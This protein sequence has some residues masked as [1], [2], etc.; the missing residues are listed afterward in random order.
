MGREILGTFSPLVVFSLVLA[1]AIYAAFSQLGSAADELAE[2][3]YQNQ[4]MLIARQAAERLADLLGAVQR[5]LDMAPVPGDL[6]DFELPNAPVDVTVR[7]LE[8]GDTAS[9][10]GLTLERQ[11]EDVR[12]L[13]QLDAASVY[14]TLFAGLGQSFDAYVWVMDHERTIVATPDA[15]QVGSRPF[16]SL[17]ADSALSAVLRAMVAGESSVGRYE[18]MGESRTRTRLIAYTPVPSRSLSVA[19]SADRAAVL[20]LTQELHTRQSWWLALFLGAL[21]ITSSVLI[22]RAVR[23]Y[24]ERLEAMSRLGPYSLGQQLGEGGMGVVFEA[25]HALLRRPTAIKLI[26]AEL[27][28]ATMLQRFEREVQMTARLTHP[29]TVTVFDYGQTDAGVFYYAMEFVDGP[30]L[31]QVVEGHGRLPQARVVHLMKQVAGALAEAHE[32]G[33][34]HRDIKPSNIMLCKRGGLFD[35]AKVLDFGLVRVVGETGGQVAGTPAYMAP[36]TFSSASN[37]GERSDVYALG[38]VA[39]YL[40]TGEDLFDGETTTELATQHAF[41][42]PEP[43]TERVPGACIDASFESVILRCLAKDPAKRPAS[44]REV[45]V[46]LEALESQWSQADAESLWLERPPRSDVSGEAPTELGL[47]HTRELGSS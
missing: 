26:H 12:L 35:V 5:E 41:D 47:A 29:N 27:S 25:K 30:T 17:S 44:A 31:W 34:I 4:Q 15:G 40:V 3:E 21:F 19:Y 16:E 10:T 33:L 6:S 13:A 2:R 39:Y 42:P 7:Q 37:V 24:R 1:A 36:E 18:W 45:L 14:E 22:W 38:A 11:V 43:P 46:A 20:A 8:R 32:A 9:A 28:T 23:R